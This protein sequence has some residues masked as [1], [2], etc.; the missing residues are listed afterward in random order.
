MSQKSRAHKR[1]RRHIRVRRRIAGTA[2]RP[3]V[4]VFRSLSQIYAQVID[5][6]TGNTLVAV[7]TVDKELREKI[8]K[9]KKS[10]Q[11]K[12][13]GAALARR[14]QQAGIKQV[15]FDRGGYRYHGRVKALAEAAREAGL[16]F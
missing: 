3:R 12:E 16:Q 7:S 4:S 8:G 6:S 9:M 15:V 11:A 1:S 13:V 2:D 10:D 5:D 14:A